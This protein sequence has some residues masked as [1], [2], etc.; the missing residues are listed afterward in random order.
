MPGESRQHA[1]MVQDLVSHIRKA[2]EP[3]GG[4]V[5]YSDTGTK[6]ESLPQRVNGHLPDVFASD[7]PT[8]FHIIGEAKTHEDLRSLR[9]KRQIKAFL[10]FL[11]LYSNSVFYL[12]V[13]VFSHPYAKYLLD[14]V[15]EHNHEGVEIHVL[16]MHTGEDPC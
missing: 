3:A 2:H 10:D 13:P 8:T 15:T 6:H 7:V 16:P 4:F 11:S 14:E 5:L 1:T 9:S 12:A